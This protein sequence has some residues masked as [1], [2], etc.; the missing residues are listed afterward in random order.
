LSQ[1]KVTKGLLDN[2]LHRV[3]KSRSDAMN[4]NELPAY[5][6]SDN[7]TGCCPRFNAKGWDEQDLH[8]QNKLFVRAK[9]RS[10]FHIPINMGQVFKKTFKAIEAAG[11]RNDQDFIV[12]SRDLSPWTSEHYF[13]V[14][15]EVPGLD[16]R[17]LS[18]DFLTKVFEGPFKNVPKW[19][20]ENV[21]LAAQ[22]GKR[23]LK[24]FF[25]YTTC[26]RCAKVYGKNFVV[27]VG[28]VG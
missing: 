12:M 14:S 27:A 5:D 13:S 11:A 8:F 9:T 4:V 1:I 26:P 23:I 3:L 25:F 18:G 6:T 22:R 16:M 10:L 28:Q 19:E 24:N 21:L 15:K 2:V 17:R 7:S 20:K